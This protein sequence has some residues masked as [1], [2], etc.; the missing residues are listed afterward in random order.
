MDLQIMPHD[1]KLKYPFAIARHTY[2]SQPNVIIRLSDGKFDGY[3]EATM[4]PYY[5]ITIESLFMAFEKIQKRLRSY[6]FTTPDQLWDDYSDMLTENPFALAALNNAAWDLFGKLHKCPARQLFQL[7]GSNTPMTCYTLGIASHEMLVKKIMDFPWPVYKIK[8]GTKDDIGLV[9]LIREHTSAIIR[10]D[11]NC[12]W[13]ADVTVKNAIAL[14]ELG[15]EYIEQPLPAN[16]PE[17]GC[18]FEESCLPLFADESCR[19]ESDVAACSEKFHG[20]NIKLLKCGGITPALRMIRDARKH[21]LKIMIGCMTETSVG[22]AAAAQLLTLVDYAD[23][24]GPLLLGEDLADG[25]RYDQGRLIVGEGNGL[26]INYHGK[27]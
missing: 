18:C 12:A 22:I 6:Q 23:L 27:L 2:F 8:L 4:N 9:R 5:G 17:Q 1:L 21:G 24:D 26:G 11:A 3:G 15:V 20:I 14:K 13:T 16:D 10:V 19:T 25:L 7:S